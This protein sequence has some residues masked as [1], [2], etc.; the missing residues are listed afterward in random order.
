MVRLANAAAVRGGGQLYQRLAGP[1]SLQAWRAGFG[2]GG[3]R[4]APRVAVR[5]RLGTVRGRATAGCGMGQRQTEREGVA[6][7]GTRG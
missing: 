7:A 3:T 4:C 1:G 6:T 2:K 5:W